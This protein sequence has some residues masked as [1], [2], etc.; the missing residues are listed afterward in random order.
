MSTWL[1]RDSYKG[2]EI[3]NILTH[4]AHSPMSACLLPP[5]FPHHQSLSF[6]SRP[7]HW[8]LPSH[9]DMCFPW[10]IC[11]STQV[12][13][14]EFSSK[15]VR[16]EEFFFSI[17]F[18]TTFLHGNDEVSFLLRLCPNAQWI[19]KSWHHFFSSAFGYLGIATSP[20]TTSGSGGTG[21]D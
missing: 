8:S 4:S 16:S 1:F 15:P 6:P 14:K 10:I 21:T 2:S 11:P 9:L 13:D 17:A 5:T 12:D 19:N 20:I 3:M 18:Q 7:G